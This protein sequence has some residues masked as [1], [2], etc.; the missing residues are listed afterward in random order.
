MRS[1]GSI[2]KLTL[3]ESTAAAARVGERHILEFESLPNR[4]RRDQRAGL[5]LDRRLHGEEVHQV[6]HEQ[7]LVRNAGERGEHRLNVRAGPGD[8][9]GQKRQLADAS[10]ARSPSR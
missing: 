1:C 6:R 4:P 2:L 10:A 9:A 8:R 5:R 7:R 3:S